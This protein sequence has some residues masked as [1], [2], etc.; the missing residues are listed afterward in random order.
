M[1]SQAF[2]KMVPEENPDISNADLVQQMAAAAK[3]Y[4]KGPRPFALQ[5]EYIAPKVMCQCLYRVK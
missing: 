5:K 1:P 3:I 2:M 4:A